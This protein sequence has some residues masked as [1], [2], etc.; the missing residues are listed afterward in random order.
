[1][2]GL[3]IMNVGGLS[4]AAL[5]SVVAGIATV[6]AKPVAAATSIGSGAGLFIGAIVAGATEGQGRDSD[7]GRIEFW[8]RRGHSL[9]NHVGYFPVYEPDWNGS[10]R[11]MLGFSAFASMGK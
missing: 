1:M 2:R 8:R 7:D 3:Q 9:W 4:G 6:R 10:G 5:G 11:P